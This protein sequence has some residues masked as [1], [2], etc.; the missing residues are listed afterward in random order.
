[1]KT[2][3][4]RDENL[5]GI[6]VGAPVAPV[7][8]GHIAR[9]VGIRGAVKARLESDD[10]HRL[11][12]MHSLT[13]RFG[14]QFRL[15]EVLECQAN[16]GWFLISLRDVGS[17]D[18]A[19]QLT[20]AEIV[21]DSSQRPRLPERVYYDD[22]IIGCFA[23]SDQGGTLGIIREIMHQG[24]HDLWVIDGGGREILVPAVGEFIAGVDLEGHRVTVKFIEGLWGSD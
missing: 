13:L 21:I 23:E 5:P 24:H 15:F 7:V 9:P 20:G 4:G 14:D 12:G 19:S 22:D 17:L 11:D 1:M 6:S 2:R 18:A 3:L 8:I 16:L 10:A